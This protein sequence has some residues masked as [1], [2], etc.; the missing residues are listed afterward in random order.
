MTNVEHQIILSDSSVKTALKQLNGRGY[1]TVLFVIDESRQLIG[2]LTDGDI[3]R[4]LLQGNDLETKVGI[5]CNPSPNYLQQEQ[6]TIFDVI[7]LRSNGYRIVPILNERREI[8]DILNFNNKRSALPIDVVIMAGGR[9]SRLQPLTN[10]TPKPL[11]IVGE[12]PIIDYSFDRL[13]QFGVSNFHITVRYLGQQI[14]QHFLQK[15]DPTASVNIIEETIPLGT[16]GAVTLVEEFK[17]DYV[18][19]TNSDILTSIDYED[20]FV[21]FLKSGADMSVVG[22]PYV[23]PIPYAV[24]HLKDDC[25]TSFEEKPTY[26]YYSNGGIYLVKTSLLKSIPKQT[27]Y[28]TTDLMES[29]LKEGGKLH[30]YRLKEYWLDVG[31]HE[32][33]KKAQ[34]DFKQVLNA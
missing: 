14:R 25:V 19:I 21:E 31:K 29:L 13:L 2:S 6:Q 33:F 34:S 32:D 26:T 10:D 8:V 5:I 18:L 11:L 28:N 1:D 4:G 22:I 30:T 15:R 7:Q 3:R 24:M 16:I 20:F 9:G 27:F 17:S 12:K 23:V